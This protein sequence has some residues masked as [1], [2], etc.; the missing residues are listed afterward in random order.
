MKQFTPEPEGPMV[1][2]YRSPEER[3]VEAQH[4]EAVPGEPAPTPGQPDSSDE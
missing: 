3:A 2:P 1:Y 4:S